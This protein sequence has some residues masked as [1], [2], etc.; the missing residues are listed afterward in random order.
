MLP[1]LVVKVLH[2]TCGVM[3]TCHPCRPVLQIRCECDT[4]CK[5]GW[6]RLAINWCSATKLQSCIQA[7]RLISMGCRGIS[8]FLSFRPCSPMRGFV[9]PSPYRR[10]VTVS[11]WI[12]DQH[13]HH[14]CQLQPVLLPLSL[15][16]SSSPSLSLTASGITVHPSTHT[17]SH[18][19]RPPELEL[20]VSCLNV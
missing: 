1:F 12:P 14:A 13:F 18:S 17:H 4:Q 8:T 15:P 16:S 6:S 5:W 11:C 20:P 2:V 19:V 7:V 10:S 3:T 9:L